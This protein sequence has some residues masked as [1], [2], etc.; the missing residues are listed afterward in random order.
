MQ[1]TRNSKRCTSLLALFLAL[2]ALI[3][4]LALAS[5]QNDAGGVLRTISAESASA[6]PNAS[7][8]TGGTLLLTGSDQAS[9]DTANW[10]GAH[11]YIGLLDPIGSSDPVTPPTKIP[12]L[13]IY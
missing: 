6:V 5:Q 11:L 1:K 7:N 2:S 9:L 8:P 10:A 12:Q 3:G 13:L 4:T